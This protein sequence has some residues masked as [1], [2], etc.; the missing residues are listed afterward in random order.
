M[1]SRNADAARIDRDRLRI[2]TVRDA[3]RL[4]HDR[5]QLL[6]VVDRALEVADVHADFAQVALQHEERGEHQRDVARVRLAAGPEQHA[7]RR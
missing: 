3:E 2:G 5:D 7:P 6:H 4:V 1:T